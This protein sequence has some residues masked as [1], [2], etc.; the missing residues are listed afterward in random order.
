[1]PWDEIT[2]Y[3]SQ[4]FRVYFAEYSAKEV[5]EKYCEKLCYGIA[6]LE[7]VIRVQRKAAKNGVVGLSTD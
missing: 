2:V 7:F 3:W 4:I 1:M 5:R 6:T